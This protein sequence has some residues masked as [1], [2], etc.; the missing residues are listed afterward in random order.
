MLQGCQLLQFYWVLRYLLI[1]LKL[2]FLGS[3]D[4]LSVLF[5][6]LKKCS[7]FLWMEKK[8]WSLKNT[9]TNKKGSQ[10]YSGRWEEELG[11][12][13]CDSLLHLSHVFGGCLWILDF[14]FA[15]L[16]LEN[17]IKE[18]IYSKQTRCVWEGKSRTILPLSSLSLTVRLVKILA[19]LK[20]AGI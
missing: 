18:Y 8:A 16:G 9:K 14:E 10:E 20:W 1:Y 6:F 3:G 11:C 19:H 13:W 7:Y 2:K 4:Y 17:G 15:V 5:P 12:Q